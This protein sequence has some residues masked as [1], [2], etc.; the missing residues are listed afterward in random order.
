MSAKNTGKSVAVAVV[1]CALF[2]ASLAVAGTTGKI[3]GRVVDR[4][5][6]EPIPG[7]AVTIIGT[8]LG[9]LSDEEG[10]YVMLSV[11]VGAYVVKAQLIGYSPME[12]SNVR[13]SVDL[14]TEVQLELVAVALEVGTIH[15]RAERP[16]II[17]DQTSSLRIV[18]REQISS[19]P[20]RSYQDI[21]GYQ[22]GVVQFL[23]NAEVR[24]RGGRESTSGPATMSIRG[25]RRSEVAYF[26]DGF[27][28]QDPQSGL[29]TTQINQNTIEEVSITTGGFNAEYGWISSGV[30]N[31]T[32]KE[33]SSKYSGTIELLTDNITAR[34]YDYNVYAG[35]F[36][37]PVPGFEEKMTFFVSGE[38]RYLGDR[39][40]R[41]TTEDRFNYTKEYEIDPVTGDTLGFRM[42]VDGTRELPSNRLSGYS[43]QGK[44]NWNITNS[45]KLKFGVL[46][47]HDD[48]S[49]Y[50][51]SFY[52]NRNHVPR[53]VDLNNSLY[54]KLVYNVNPKTFFT[55]AVNYFMTDRERGD[56]VHF[57]DIWSYSRPDANF[58]FDETILFWSGDNPNTP[59]AR[60]HQLMWD[61]TYGYGYIAVET[62][63]T[64]EDGTPVTRD[65][66][67]RDDRGF[68]RN[69]RYRED[70]DSALAVAGNPW[71]SDL[72][73][74]DEDGVMYADEGWV[75]EDYRKRRSSYYGFQADITSQV[76]RNH[77]V[78][79]GIDYQYHTL[80]YYRHLFPHAAFKD[81]VVDGV[82][83][84]HGGFDDVDH[85]GYDIFGNESDTLSEGNEARH[86][87]NFAAYLQDKFEWE[88]LVVNA[89]LRFDYLNVNTKRLKFPATPLGDPNDDIGDDNVLD[90][91]DMEEAKAETKLS[92]RLGFG[93][94]ISDKTTFHLSYGK[95]FQRPD[96]QNL[97]VG[98][99]YME[100]R[101]TS[102]GYYYPFGNPNLRPEKTTAYEIGLTKQVGDYT[103]LDITA[104]YKDISDLTQLIHQ[105]VAPGAAGRD[106][107]LYDNA[108]F[109]TVKGLELALNM[110]RNHNVALDINYSLAWANGTGSWPNTQRNIVW[111]V[112]ESPKMTSPLDF[113]QRHK[114]SA[115][116]D[117][118]AGKGEGPKIGES[119]PLENAGVNFHFAAGSGTPYSPMNIF[120]ETTLAAVSP[121]PD[122]AINSE[123]SPWTYRLDLKANKVF[124][125]GRYGMELYVWVLNL[126]N[127]K[128][129]ID[130]YEATGQ[131]SSTAWL[132]TEDGQAFIE[133]NKVPDWTG[134]NGRQKYELK[135]NNPNS[136]GEPLQVR[137][138][139]KISF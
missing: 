32:T 128:N 11:P 47:S 10:R 106:F 79:A 36:S 18:D 136:Y 12:V 54:G 125:M 131:A 124:Y 87:Y 63:D 64:L 50:Q 66:V 21:V 94:P 113:D 42:V 91:T 72:I 30:I 132:A 82:W 93:F 55:A 62:G 58:T 39:Q 3:T 122:G 15:V 123:Y 22:A 90:P 103:R 119:Y 139:V 45:M 70:V 56:G 34:S 101:L 38:R 86:P 41:S 116:V 81:S 98:W 105:S 57:D 33:G 110:R 115:T 135:Q 73:A 111:T 129:E 7:A 53:Y 109:G 51:H 71:V 14:T 43:W 59:S 27:S 127:R 88:G 28:Q 40:P 8:V 83:Y 60:D 130:V 100:Y 78:K 89:G 96:L 24:A 108:D 31:V 67:V 92:P 80:R 84:D 114:L 76:H 9:A 20:T 112:S 126:L 69:G 61:T 17:K 23:D 46:G 95:Y 85:F 137:F 48:W 4:E 97:Y 102:A 74:R 52:F 77:E 44:L 19:L 104:Y 16:L 65:V 6:G 117:I 107:D 118:R 138:G 1:V 99:D 25:G 5:T 121:S 134:L 133:S 26:V 2:V 68:V 37:G 49:E 29:S 35:D 120:N 75:W 13:V